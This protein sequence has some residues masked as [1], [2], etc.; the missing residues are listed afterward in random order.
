MLSELTATAAEA[1]PRRLVSIFFGGGTPSLMD[2]GTVATVIETAASLWTPADDLEVTL[3]ANPTSVE[4]SRFSGYAAAGVN[5]LSLG[6]QSFDDES[7]VFLGREHTA[8]A[9]RAAIDTARRAFSRYSFDLIY[10]RPGQSMTAWRNE[11]AEAL[12]RADGHLSLYQLTIEPGTPFFRDRVAPCDDDLGAEFYEVTGEMTAAAGL[13]VYEVSNHAR[14]GDACRHNLACWLGVDYA[15]IGPG[16]HGRLTDNGGTWAL[17]RKAGPEAWL[18]AVETDGHGTAKRTRL[19][20]TARGEELLL[21]GLRLNDG[22]D[23][24]VFKRR[25]GVPLGSLIEPSALARLVAGGFLVERTGGLTATPA[26]LLRLDA[27]LSTLL[28]PVADGEQSV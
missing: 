25:A 1:G 24:A 7:L 2:P 21:S 8:E 26:G 16:A 10:A 19:S 17:Y 6:V 3:E 18:G 4:A 14:P 23:A 28:A 15:G 20:A 5:R 12:D 27:V 22:I 11:L 13:P 9:A